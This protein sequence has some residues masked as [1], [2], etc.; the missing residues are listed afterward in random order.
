MAFSA[1]DDQRRTT[2]ATLRQVVVDYDALQED[3]RAGLALHRQFDMALALVNG[4]AG[5]SG[6]WSSVRHTAGKG[7]LL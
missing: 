6:A 7:R 2:A 3:K 4:L 5:H 1:A